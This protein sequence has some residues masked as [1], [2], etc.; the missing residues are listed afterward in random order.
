M[1]A[2]VLYFCLWLVFAPVAFAA[3]WTKVKDLQPG[4]SIRT[5]DGWEKIKSIE[6]LPPE[7][8]YDISISNTHN[9]VGNGI[10]AHNTS[11]TG[12]AIIAG[13]EWDT[14]GGLITRQQK[15]YDGAKAAITV[16][17]GDLV[18]YSGETTL[19]SREDLTE[20]LYKVV[21][22]FGRSNDAG[23]TGLVKIVNPDGQV[24]EMPFDP[25]SYGF[26]NKIIIP[27]ALGKI[28]I[29]P[30]YKTG[31]VGLGVTSL[32]L[33]AMVTG[34]VCDSMG[35]GATSWCSFIYS[36]GKNYYHML[37]SPLLNLWNRNFYRGDY[38]GN[39]C[40]EGEIR[41]NTGVISYCGSD[42][43][44]HLVTDP[45]TSAVYIG[46]YNQS[47]IKKKQIENK[48][49]LTLNPGGD[50]IQSKDLAV[51]ENIFSD[52]P[53]NFSRGHIF[54]IY[55][56]TDKSEALRSSTAAKNNDEDI[57]ITLN[58]SETEWQLKLL[59]THELLHSF[60]WINTDSDFLRIL[61]KYS[62]H[63]ENGKIIGKTMQ[64]RDIQPLDVVYDCSSPQT[65][66]FIACAG[67]LYYLNPQ[68]LK[69]DFPELYEFYKN[70][71]YGGKEYI[72][73][74]APLNI[75]EKNVGMKDFV[76]AV[77]TVCPTCQALETDV[78]RWQN[79]YGITTVTPEL[80][81]AIFKV[82]SNFN[83]GAKNKESGAFGV[84]QLLPKTQADDIKRILADKNL[85]E[86]QKQ[87]IIKDNVALSVYH[88]S[89]N[90]KY[91]AD[92]TSPADLETEQKMI[93][94]AY[95]LGA[96]N[97]VNAYNKAVAGRKGT[98]ADWGQILEQLKSTGYYDKVGKYVADVA[99]FN[100]RYVLATQEA[101][102]PAEL[103]T[104]VKNISKSGPINETILDR[105]E[106]LISSLRRL[107]MNT[108][109][110]NLERLKIN[111]LSGRPL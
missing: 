4:Q 72:K 108:Q 13:Y 41:N 46:L 69:S 56:F 95:Y 91:I 9:F 44:F 86:F 62:I 45:V 12:K 70:R 103:M 89:W 17:N 93:T 111:V 42:L 107:G 5:I 50:Y 99:S 59:V 16:K 25:T 10:V 101:G 28:S 68:K 79:I 78:V 39:K 40:S 24:L 58:P 47:D 37:Y 63:V 53:S 20:M 22:K 104:M 76:K 52:L 1:K 30:N 11:V 97:V 71:V 36:A 77:G 80:A 19:S 2:F 64:S 33:P 98:P 73:P 31:V 65:N 102:D 23:N 75:M 74:I 110:E 34:L 109:A 7:Q 94:A 96:Q 100:E 15:I 81:S 88:M 92:N 18:V 66:E 106:F 83:P 8:V 85:T 90:A 61:S 51:I 87:Q 67:D 105:A 57:I 82:E 60:L 55:Y 3:D 49:G 27:E 35:L 29:K 84:G 6:L 21:N 43:T 14:I 48:Y 38:I 26:F 32:G 54:Y